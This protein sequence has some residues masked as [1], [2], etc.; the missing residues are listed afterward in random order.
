MSKYT[1]TAVEDK[2]GVVDESHLKQLEDSLANAQ[3]DVEGRL[4]PRLRDME[5]QEAAQR[6][7]LL[8][9][10]TDIDTIL[11]D[12]TNLEDILRAI[13]KGCYNSPPIEEA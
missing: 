6:R 2:P 4:R 7:R 1:H 12:I 10:N 13:P 9:I 5:D 8:G 11:G 3:R